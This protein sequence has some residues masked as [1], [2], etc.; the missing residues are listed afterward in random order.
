[1][2]AIVAELVFILLPFTGPTLSKEANWP[3]LDPWRLPP[4]HQIGTIGYI[5]A[6]AVAAIAIGAI[7][8]ALHV[9]LLFMHRSPRW[10]TVAGYIAIALGII[11]GLMLPVFVF[12]CER[13]TFKE[14][15]RMNRPIE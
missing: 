6:S 11:A 12:R 13:I 14:S 15:I 1:M 2:V 7:V 5:L 3:T 10:R 8:S 4:P 9:A